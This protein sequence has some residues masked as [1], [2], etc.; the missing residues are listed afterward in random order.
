VPA[1]GTGDIWGS[2]LN[3]TSLL[4]G[5]LAIGTCTFLAGVLLTADAERLGQ[6][7]LAEELRT[8]SLI[9]GVL[10]GAVVLTGIPI[11]I[12]DD[13]TLVDGLLG[14]ALPLVIGSGVA[15]LGALWLLWHRGRPARVAAAGAVALVVAGW[16]AG[17][18]PWLLV[19]E[20]TIDDAAGASATLIGLLVAAGLA[21]VLVAPPLVYLFNLV[22]T[23]QA[24]DPAPREHRTTAPGS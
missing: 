22:D 19:D 20:L 14:R 21:L 12:A 1:E 5:F 24:A 6:G 11:L 13:Q 7:D 15:G 9:G 23:E 10:T 17:Q 8:K 16:G 4:G 2:W 3:P 18:Y